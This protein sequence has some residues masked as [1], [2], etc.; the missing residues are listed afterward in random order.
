MVQITAAAVHQ[1]RDQ[2]ISRGPGA[3]HGAAQRTGAIVQIDGFVAVL[4][5]QALHIGRDDVVG[6]FPTNALKFAFTARPDSFHR[7]FQAVRIIDTATHGTPTQTGANL[8]QAVVIVIAGIVRFDI[9]DFTVHDV[10]T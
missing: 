8:V 10:H 2:G 5:D 6:F 3:G 9:F 4:F 1:A 7:I